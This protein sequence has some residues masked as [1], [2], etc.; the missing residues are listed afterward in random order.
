[1]VHA[2]GSKEAVALVVVQSPRVAPVDPPETSEVFRVAVGKAEIVRLVSIAIGMIHRV[3][4]TSQLA[5]L[6]EF[7]SGFWFVFVVLVKSRPLPENV[8]PQAPLALF[9]LTVPAPL[10]NHPVI[11]KMRQLPCSEAERVKVKFPV[12]LPVQIRLAIS[13]LDAPLLLAPTFFHV[14]SGK[15]VELPMVFPSVATKA[16]SRSPAAMLVG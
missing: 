13:K 7:G 4:S 9:P 5:G 1:M 8:L 15:T 6:S 2:D 11:L 14:A 10:P 12:S 3:S 16:S